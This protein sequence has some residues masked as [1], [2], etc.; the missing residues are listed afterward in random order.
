LGGFALGKR[1][2]AGCCIERMIENGEVFP[3]ERYR[4]RRSGCDAF[5]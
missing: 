1:A 3:S 4:V 5:Q 2:A